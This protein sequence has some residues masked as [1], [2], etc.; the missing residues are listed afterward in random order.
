[1]PRRKGASVAERMRAKGFIDAASAEEVSGIPESTLRTWAS[2]KRVRTCRVGTFV[3]FE[4]ASL[5]DVAG[6]LFPKG[7]TQCR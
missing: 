4:I 2:T 7:D 1:M 5:Q 3:F 6:P